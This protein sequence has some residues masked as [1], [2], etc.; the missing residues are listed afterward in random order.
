M[1]ENLLQNLVHNIEYE[2]F[3]KP[4]SVINKNYTLYHLHLRK[5]GGIY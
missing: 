5:S 3:L 4:S 2:T 1:S